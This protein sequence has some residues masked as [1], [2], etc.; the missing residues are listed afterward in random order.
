VRASSR[1]KKLSTK[2]R[3]TSVESRRSLGAWKEPTL[4]AREWRRAA[5]EVLGA[6]GSCTCTKSSS[7]VVS[8]S[9][10]VRATSIDSAEVR[11]RALLGTSSTSPTAITAGVP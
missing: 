2:R 11:R 7:T 4:S 9:S 3:A 6:N 1:P 8:S 5:L 10:T